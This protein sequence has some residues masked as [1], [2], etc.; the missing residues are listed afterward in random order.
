MKK[1]AFLDRDGVINQKAAVEGEYITRCEELKILPGVA[2]AI[3]L[4]HQAGFQVVVV[5]NQRCVAKGLLTETALGSMHRKLCDELEALGAPIDAVYYCPH[6]QEPPCACRKPKP[7]M[8]LAAATECK[9]DLTSS[10][11]IGDSE[12]DIEAGKRAGCRT[13]RIAKTEAHE[14]IKADIRAKSLL[15]AVQMMIRLEGKSI[16]SPA[17]NTS[18]HVARS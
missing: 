18:V 16:E 10:W 8:L 9:I 6:D 2:E 14:N 1:A 3:R 15:E 13:A 7:G 5:T 4:L 17:P 11:M 12:K